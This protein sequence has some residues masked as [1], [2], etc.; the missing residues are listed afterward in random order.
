M[1]KEKKNQH[2]GA[3]AGAGRPK[4]DSKLY[5]FRCPG[6]LARQLDAKEN[7]WLELEEIKESDSQDPA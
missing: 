6:D 5:S 7:R 3:R 1:D 2:G 4:G